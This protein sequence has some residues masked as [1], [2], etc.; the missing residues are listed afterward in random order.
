MQRG[1]RIA[2]ACSIIFCTLACLA[3]NLGTVS[4]VE[5]ETSQS[6]NLVEAS[7]RSASPEDGTPPDDAAAAETGAAE[8]PQT[9]TA[10][11]E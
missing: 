4:L 3:L 2:A 6:V 7:P 11:A 1:A 8:T 9:E 10:S 5:D